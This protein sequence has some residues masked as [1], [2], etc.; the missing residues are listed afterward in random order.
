MA[1]EIKTVKKNKL[2]NLGFGVLIGLLFAS[3][4]TV[5]TVSIVSSVKNETEIEQLKSNYNDSQTA[6]ASLQEISEQTK[7][8]L[9]STKAAKTELETQKLALEAEKANLETA[10]TEL[11]TAKA[12]LETQKTTLETEKTNLQTAKATLETQ[13]ASLEIEK[14][15]LELDKTNLETQKIAAETAKAQ[16][17]A[18]LAVYTTEKTLTI[19]KTNVSVTGTAPTKI[20]ISSPKEIT[21]TPDSGYHLP[22]SVLVTGCKYA[23]DKDVGCLKLYNPTGDV[24]VGINAIKNST[25]RMDLNKLEFDIDGDTY[26]YDDALYY[27]KNLTVGKTSKFIDEIDS[28]FTKVNIGRTSND[29]VSA[30]Y[31]TTSDGLYVSDLYILADDEIVIDE[32]DRRPTTMLAGETIIELDT[33]ADFEAYDFSTCTEEFTYFKVACDESLGGVTVYYYYWKS[34]DLVEI[35]AY[36]N[37]PFSDLEIAKRIVIQNVD[38]RNVK[39]F[40][41][42]FGYSYDANYIDISGLD[43]DS[44]TNMNSM[45]Y[46]CQSLGYVDGSKIRTDNVVNTSSMFEGC[47]AL[48]YLDLSNCD[49]RNVTDMSSMF[50]SD[51]DLRELS[52]PNF[53]TENVTNMASMFDGTGCYEIDISNFDFSNVTSLENFLCSNDNLYSVDLPDTIDTSNVTNMAAMLCQTPN[54]NDFEIEKFDT[55]AVTT[56]EY[57]FQGS[58][59]VD[60]D[61]S[62][63]DTSNVTNMEFMFSESHAYDLDLTSFDTSK[64]TSMRY[65][66]SGSEATSLDV[67]SF[68][69]SKVTNFQHMFAYMNEITELDVYSFDT[70]SATDVGGMFRYCPKLTTIIVSEDFSNWNLSSAYNIDMFQGSTKLVGAAGTT[71]DM[72]ETD[73]DYARIDT[74]KYGINP[75][76]PLISNDGRGYFSTKPKLTNQV[77]DSTLIFENDSDLISSAYIEV[78]GT[79]Y[80]FSRSGSG[81]PL[82]CDAIF[83]IGDTLLIH[84]IANAEIRIYEYSY[85][86][87][88]SDEYFDRTLVADEN[89][90]TDASFTL[91]TNRNYYILISFP[92]V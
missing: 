41:F 64:V 9:E 84:T 82:I 34:L 38:T 42:Y 57:M 65:M 69:T 83:E 15:Q 40:G 87:L 59:M 77:S 31:K 71:F 86:S 12:N 16:A 23:Y 35:A 66:F 61:L 51:Y 47:S 1:D 8:D 29:D 10:K 76:D 7:T 13:V 22:D 90:V 32:T 92:A 70:I 48:A 3:T 50:C 24:T 18:D 60:P 72:Y 67:S 43:F 14:A 21:F 11:E 45:F 62:H 79:K 75:D 39:N 4:V 37:G 55:S 49:T 91:T 73:G 20:S 78:K 2:L 80:Y 81:Y 85:S 88:Y 26:S 54:L 6:Y 27:I 36:D 89:G 74:G 19:N 46:G 44:A 5:S 56:M 30:Y 28:G 25:Y 68:D 58:G 52:L 63:F 33:H 17:E 53:N